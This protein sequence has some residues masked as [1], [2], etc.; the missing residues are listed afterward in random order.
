[1]ARDKAFLLEGNVSS[2]PQA[3][4][5]TVSHLLSRV[6]TLVALGFSAAL[7]LG[8]NPA[9]TDERLEWNDLPNIEMSGGLKAFWDVHDWTNGEN[10]RNAYAHGFKPITLLLTYSD[11]P[12]NQRERIVPAVGERGWNPWSKP[13]FFERIVRRNIENSGTN[14]VYVHDIEFNFDMSAQKAWSDENLRTAARA[15]TFEEFEEA[16]LQEWASWHYLPMKWTKEK[17]H[18]SLVGLYGRQPYGRDFWGVTHNTWDEM[19]AEHQLDWRLWK[20]IDPYADFYISSIYNFYDSPDSVFYMATNVELN[21]QRARRLGE[22]PVYAYEWMRYHDSNKLEGNRELDPYLVEAMAVVPYF[23]GAQAIVLWGHEPRLK[24]GDG[25]PYRQLPLYMETLAR[26]ARLSKKIGEGKLVIDEPAR[27]LWKEKRP[28]IRRIEV[29]KDECVVLAIN[30]WQSEPQN[31]TTDVLCGTKRHK[32]SM[33][34]RHA[35]LAHIL[36]E[37]IALQ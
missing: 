11:Y 4:I 14:D 10:S 30:P 25:R 27:A 36:G 15:N 8:Q 21:Y 17:Y 31:S 19:G 12:G 23:S 24:P 29:A 33:Q 26:V 35:T 2:M 16:Y 1:M 34:G 5:C 37:T 22:R 32:L 6:C 9:Q 3:S 7:G 13:E 18:N 28:L 20:M